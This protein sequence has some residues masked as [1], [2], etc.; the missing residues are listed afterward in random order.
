MNGYT[1]NRQIDVDRFSWPITHSHKSTY[2]ISLSF[3]MQYALQN[4]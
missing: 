3:N 1:T 4:I 2:V